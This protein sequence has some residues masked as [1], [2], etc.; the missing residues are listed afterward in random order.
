M[1]KIYQFNSYS[2]K[3]I[4][5]I[6]V[7]FNLRLRTILW[8]IGFKKFFYFFEALKIYQLKENKKNFNDKLI[9]ERSKIFDPYIKL[10]RQVYKLNNEWY[11]LNKKLDI[12]KLSRSQFIDKSDYLYLY[13][14]FY[15]DLDFDQ[16]NKNLLKKIY[17]SKLSYQPFINSQQIFNHFALA[18]SLYLKRN[19]DYIFS[20][21]KI[22]EKILNIM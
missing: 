6:L 22:L 19:E 20:I 9:L 15:M 14:F 5:I 13:T 4:K 17:G 8:R 10:P 21:Y 3:I 12:D 18:S 1:E 7:I 16:V 2:K 11:V